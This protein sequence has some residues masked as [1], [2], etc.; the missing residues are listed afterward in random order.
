MNTQ[1]KSFAVEVREGR[2]HGWCN[3][4]MRFASAPEAKAYAIAFAKLHPAVHE[5]RVVESTDDV[6]GQFAEG[7]LLRKGGPA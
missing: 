1:M 6:N 7:E 2:Q 3:N 4:G 5:F